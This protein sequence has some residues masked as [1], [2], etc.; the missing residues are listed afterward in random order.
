M[1]APPREIAG[2]VLAL[3]GNPTTPPGTPGQIIRVVKLEPCECPWVSALGAHPLITN[4]EINLER[5]EKEKGG[6]EAVAI[7]YAWGEFQRTERLIGHDVEGNDIRMTLGEEWNTQDFV[8]RLVLLSKRGACW[9]DQLCIPQKD[10]EVRRALASIPT[11]YRSLDVV[12]LMPGAPCKCLRERVEDLKIAEEFGGDG[13]DGIATV[14]GTTMENMVRC[15]NVIPCS[16][17]FGRVWTRQELLYSRRIS[18]AWTGSGDA[19]CV[20][21][22]A[23][24]DNSVYVSTE[25]A[26]D[27]SPFTRLLHHQASKEKYDEFMG[28]S[29][30][31]AVKSAFQT[32]N[33][34]AL[35]NALPALAN[36]AVEGILSSRPFGDSEAGQRVYQKA[37]EGRKLIERSKERWA[38][39]SDKNATGIVGGAQTSLL[40][41]AM[42]AFKEYNGQSNYEAGNDTLA[43]GKA[44]RFFAGEEVERVVDLGTMDGGSQL[45][46][47]IYSLGNLR[48]S[49]RTSTQARDYINS[50]WVDCPG[51][52]FPSDYKA[53]DPPALL[54][55][56]LAQLQA[57]HNLTVVTAIPAGLLGSASGTGIWKPSL[58]LP[59]SSVKDAAHVE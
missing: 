46:W 14:I 2:Q 28:S 25:Q 49:G 29:A 37:E 30:T 48:Q 51:F 52:Q 5:L 32:A 9:I 16:S 45:E 41:T 54:G 56:A 33:P 31:A 7:S 27:L 8:N 3:G 38:E 23:H 4:H 36:T 40:L 55:D 47:F 6:D 11:I 22:R 42:T 21:L 24:T 57:N 44:L 13:G 20:E 1:A 18:V 59:K 12:V 39:A 58:Y 53:M 50:V 19:P 43:F 35:F 34:S 15:H 10:A 26:S 17:W